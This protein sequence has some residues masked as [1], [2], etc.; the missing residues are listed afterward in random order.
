MV[1]LHGLD[2]EPANATI[3]HYIEDI[4]Q[5]DTFIIVG[6]LLYLLPIWLYKLK[7]IF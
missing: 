5:T 4:S 7:Y 1:G 6:L 2:A 3:L